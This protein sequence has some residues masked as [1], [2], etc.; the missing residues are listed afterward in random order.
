MW[1]IFQVDTIRIRWCHT[2]T[3]N[4]NNWAYIDS[5][6]RRVRLHASLLSVYNCIS[7]ELVT[8]SLPWSHPGQSQIQVLSWNSIYSYHPVKKAWQAI[9]DIVLLYTSKLQQVTVILLTL[10][11]HTSCI[12]S[13]DILYA[14][15]MET[16]VQPYGASISPMRQTPTPLHYF[17]S[18]PPA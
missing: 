2:S 12:K 17:F 16:Q 11:G 4:S 7:I 8:E 3:K 18:L 13:Y 14:L 9:T 10:Q 15:L 6:A 1:P 5:K